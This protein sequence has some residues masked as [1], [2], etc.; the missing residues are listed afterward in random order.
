LFPNGTDVDVSAEV[1]CGGGGGG[2][3]FDFP[4]GSIHLEWTPTVTSVTVG[5]GV[6]PCGPLQVQ[7]SYVFPQTTGG[8]RVLSAYAVDADGGESLLKAYLCQGGL[9]LEGTCTDALPPAPFGTKQIKV[10]ARACDD[11]NATAEASATMPSNDLDPRCLPIFSDEPPMCEAGLDKGAPVR[12]SNGNMRYNERLALPT[13]MPALTALTFDTLNTDTGV[14]GAGWFSAFD[15]RLTVDVDSSDYRYR[16][17][18][19]T[20]H[21][22]YFDE[23]RRQTW[24]AT[25]ALSE[26]AF[27][28]IGGTV[29]RRYTTP[30]GDL[31]RYYRTSDGRLA[32]LE[33]PA[34]GA[35]VTIDYDPSTG[36]P[37]AVFDESG[38]WSWTIDPDTVDPNLIGTI[39]AGD[40]SWLF[41]YATTLLTEVTVDGGTWREFEYDVHGRLLEASAGQGQLIESHEYDPESGRAFNS[42]TADEHIINVEYEVPSSQ[43]PR[44]LNTSALEYAARVTWASGRYTDYFI[45][46]TVGAPHRVVEIRGDCSCPGGGDYT[47]FAYD[48]L[49]RIYREQDARGYIT[50]WF[51]DGQNRITRIERGHWPDGCDPAD[52]PDDPTVCRLDTDE[53]A[54]TALSPYGMLSAVDYTYDETWTNKAATVCTDSLLGYVGRACDSFTYDPVTGAVLT[55]GRSGYAW[56][57]DDWGSTTEWQDRSSTRQMY[58]G[59]EGAAFDPTMAASQIGVSIIFDPSWANLPQPANAVKSVDGPRPP[60]DAD[61][62]SYFVYYPEDPA[63]LPAEL[64]GRLAARME[65]E[66]GVVFFDGYDA[67][68]NVTRTVDPTGVA[69]FRQYDSLGRVTTSTLEGIPGCD[70]AADPL[71]ATDLVTTYEYLRGA[72]SL[73][74]VTSP[75]G[76]VTGYEYDKWGRV[77]TLARGPGDSGSLFTSKAKPPPL[78]GMEERI[79]TTYDRSTGD[80]LSESLERWESGSWVERKRTDYRYDAAGRL[81][82]TEYPDTAV[83]AYEYDVQGNV[84]SF[85]NPLQYGEDEPNVKYF[86]DPLGRLVEVW[87]LEDAS[88]LPFEDAWAVTSYVY[89]AHSNLI[90]VT[91]ANGD[92][93]TYWVDDFGQTYA[94]WSRTGGGYVQT[95]Y[96][97]AGQPVFE[98]DYRYATATHTYDAAGR[99]EQSVYDWW[100]APEIE[101]ITTTYDANGRRLTAD[102]GDLLE[103]WAYDRRG[104]PIYS[105]REEEWMGASVLEEANFSYSADGALETITYPSGRQV[106]YGLDYAG[107]PA[108]V[109]ATGPGG[110][111]GF[112]DYVSDVSYLPFGP[113]DAVTYPLFG[114]GTTDDRPHD[115]RYRLT[116][117]NPGLAE[118]LRSYSYDLASNLLT[119]DNPS[120]IADE[121][122]TYDDMGRLETAS[123]AFGAIT[124]DYDPVGNLLSRTAVGGPDPGVMNLFYTRTWYDFLLDWVEITPEGQGTIIHDI[125]HD[126][127]GNVLDDGVSSYVWGARPV[128]SSHQQGGTSADYRDYDYTAD[129]IMMAER[130]YTVA[131]V[132]SY[133][134]LVTTDSPSGQR[135]AE[136]LWDSSFAVVGGRELVWLGD[137]LIATF[138]SGASDPDYVFTDHIG[139]PVMVMDP[140]KNTL[141]SSVHEPYGEAVL[142][143]GTADGDPLLRYP[144]QWK[145]NPAFVTTTPPQRN[146]FA[147]GYRWYNPDWGRYT[148]SD[149]VG[150]PT[151]SAALNS[152]RVLGRTRL[153]I[154]VDHTLFSYS[155]SNPVRFSDPLGLFS[156]DS[157]DESCKDCPFDVEK[158]KAAFELAEKLVDNGCLA[159][160]DL[161]DCMKGK[162]DV[163]IFCDKSPRCFPPYDRA[164]TSTVGGNYIN[165]CHAPFI[166]EAYFGP[167]TEEIERTFFHEWTHTCGT[168]DKPVAEARLV[169]EQAF[170][171][172]HS[173]KCGN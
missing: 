140:S 99:R 149:P 5:P 23:W 66:G 130:G 79:L 143:G 87:Q 165:L 38:A 8:D 156:M 20:N 101:T 13:S 22:I 163:P 15:A 16:V 104:L 49:G 40:G 65:P 167:G 81:E 2:Y 85:S 119:A 43:L 25:G 78:D 27:V 52:Y 82:E 122:Y 147:N 29:Y 18:T 55:S 51:Y 37:T 141:W 90:E 172:Y 117:Q 123:G 131:P 73:R 75:N 56:I 129:G 97:Y 47:A 69:T 142:T 9:Q 139:Y 57:W 98:R 136:T 61:D 80:R 126:Y 59:V 152:R 95:T 160:A 64:R 144:G 21:S 145:D 107:R 151:G 166:D 58:D 26:L 146:L 125:T 168:V 17:V 159:R 121:A 50:V 28:N 60:T 31:D 42:R 108:S 116:S 74:T 170:R 1:H 14:F 6:D 34:T 155:S 105:S 36:M 137:R 68:G 67:L 171:W 103:T 100:G 118:P 71:C 54:A 124:Y 72:G 46:P 89:D 133:A 12:L 110:A 134:Q 77:E 135:L 45:R 162:R 10:V 127:M 148:Q 161:A 7:A 84:V 132:G 96:N 44:A 33:D 86:Y 92:L 120:G 111:G 11:D 106:T 93:T 158:I 48:S 153:G 70:T 164:G 128:M 112:T 76:N 63:V 35:A 169:T 115:L 30:T 154:A 4:L 91:D 88:L 19:E 62:T 102:S 150:E 24:P 53:L 173:D 157:I 114:A 32:R 41:A 113:A 39:T 83:E 3:Y 94:L 138:D 109:S